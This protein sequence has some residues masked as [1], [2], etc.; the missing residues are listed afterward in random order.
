MNDAYSRLEDAL[1]ALRDDK[2]SPPQVSVTKE[3][4]DLF[5]PLEHLDLVRVKAHKGESESGSGDG[6]EYLQVVN[7][8]RDRVLDAST[9]RWTTHSWNLGWCRADA[10]V[11]RA[12]CWTMR[13][14]YRSEPGHRGEPTVISHEEAARRL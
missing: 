7:R 3:V 10:T 9:G 2:H 1:D 14:V 6:F 5:D 12:M 13:V 11:L 4:Y 8:W